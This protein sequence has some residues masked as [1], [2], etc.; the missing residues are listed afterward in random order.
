M[1]VNGK[2][3]LVTATNP[4]ID[5][6]YLAIGQ[7]PWTKNVFKLFPQPGPLETFH[8]VMAFPGYSCRLYSF[9]LVHTQQS[10]RDTEAAS[11]RHHTEGHPWH[12]GMLSLPANPNKDLT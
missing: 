8:T 10:K 11:I 6:V 9:P 12:C 2:L 5:K 4:G 1:F 7:V 3:H